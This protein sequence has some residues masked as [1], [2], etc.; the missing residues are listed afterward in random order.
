[1]NINKA[2]QT[3][4]QV[5]SSLITRKNNYNNGSYLRLLDIEQ[6]KTNQACKTAFTHLVH[7]ERARVKK[8]MGTHRAHKAAF[9]HP[10]PDGEGTQTHLEACQSALKCYPWPPSGQPL[11]AGREGTGWDAGSPA[12]KLRK[13]R[14]QPPSGQP[15][16]AGRGSTG[17]DA[18]APA[19]K[20]RKDRLSLLL[21]SLCTQVV[22][23]QVV[24]YSGR[25]AVG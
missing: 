14:L 13:D 15:L 17:W 4:Q 3:L 6:Q 7:F 23:V 20:I 21:G 5:T 24:G 12:I 8:S 22:K 19:I 16:H 9:T 10:V 25:L 11:H 1:M 18:G 2:K